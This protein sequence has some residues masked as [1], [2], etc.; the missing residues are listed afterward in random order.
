MRYGNR[1]AK[2]NVKVLV[3]LLLVVV[4]LGVSLVAARQI[5]RRILSQMALEAGTAAFDNGDWAT[6]ASR[7]QEYLGRNPDDIEI[8]K[9]YAEAR[10]SVRPLEPASV[11]R[12]ISAYRRVMQLD[13]NDDVA[14]E[15]L[16]RLYTAVQ[17]FPDLAYIARRR[18]EQAQDDKNARLWLAEA[19][20]RL[21]KSGEARNVL[22]MLR[23]DL[24]GLADKHTEYVRVCALMSQIVSAE[25]TAAARAEGLQ[26]LDRAVAYDPNSVE[27]LAQRAG[28]RRQVAER[29]GAGEADRDTFMALARADLEAADAIGTDTPKY[30]YFLGW[31]W[32]VHGDLERAE[33]ELRAAQ[34]LPE[35]AVKEHFLDVRDWTIAKF[36]LASQLM[37]QRGNASE[38][39]LLVDEVLPTLTARRHRVQVLPTAVRVYVTAGRVADARKCLDEYVEAQYA[40]VGS[41]SG[42]TGTAEARLRLAFLRALVAQAEDNAYGVIDVLQPALASDPAR[43]E[44]WRLLAEA[45]SRTDQPRRAVSALIQYLRL[46][47]RDPDMM[48]QLAKEYLKLRDW[49]NAF[50]T[51]R[52][53]ESPDPTDIVLRL[54]RIEASIYVATEQEQT[55]DT[56]RLSALSDELT[57]LR[58]EHPDR[59]DIRILQAMIAVYLDQP[60]KAEEELRLAIDECDEPLRAEMQLIRHLYRTKRLEE[61]VSLCQTACERHPEVA[62]PWL[63]LSGLY[64]AQADNDSA[65]ACLREGLKAVVGKWEQR[66]VSL[67]LALLELMDGDRG[68]G[69]GILTG[70]AAQDEREVYARTLLLGTREIQ[71]NRTKAQELIEE[72]KAAEGQSGLMWRLHQAA[73]HL[74]SDDWRSKQQDMAELLQQCIDSDP[75]WSS[76]VLLL[77]EM[78][79]KLNDES[80]VESV[81]RQGLVRNPSATDIADKLMGLL[82]KQG[83]YADAEQVLQQIEADAQVA[84]AWHVRMALGTRDFSRAI[85]E[86]RLRVDNDNRDAESRILLAR[87]L[88]WQTRDAQQ[89]FRYLDE[90]QEITSGSLTLAAARASILRAEGRTE[91]G[92]DVLDEYVTSR[93]DF[94]AYMMRAA[95]LA[96]EGNLEAAES[97]YRKLT[98][99]EQ[100]SSMGHMLLANFYAIHSRLDDAV[101]TLREGLRVQP[102][103]LG[104]RRALMMTLLQRGQAEDRQQA[105]DMLASLEA[106]MPEDPELMRLRAMQ[107]LREPTP[108]SLAAAT[109]KLEEV[110]KLEPTAVDAH[111][112]LIEIALQEGD[113]AKAREMA[114]RALGANP[115]NAALLAA[116][117]RVELALE[118][119]QM[120]TQLANL[121]LQADPNNAQARDVIVTAAQ[122]T[123]DRALLEQAVTLVDKWLAH[124]PTNEQLTLRRARLMVALQQPRKAIPELEAYCRTEAGSRDVTALVTLADVYRL[125]GN[126]EK[127]KEAID[128]AEA[129]DP[130]SQV[131]AHARLLWLIAQKRYNE[132]TGVVSTYLAVQPRDAGMLVKAGRALL[133]CDA[134][135]AKTEAVRLFERVLALDPT[136]LDGRLGLASSLYQAGQH[137]RAEQIRREVLAENIEDVNAC[138]TIASTLYLTGYAEGGERIY[139]NLLQRDPN[140]TRVLN[141]L[142]WIIQEHYQRYDE[143]LALA[144][145][146]LAVS[147]R[148]PAESVDHVHLLD[149]RGTIL[150]NMPGRLADA[151]RDFEEI[152][153]LSATNQ[154]RQAKALLQLGRVC[155]KQGDLAQAK[156]H[157]ERSL[158]VDRR[159]AVFTPAEKSEIATLLQ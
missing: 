95:Y 38:S 81:C 40:Q 159:L 130:N 58:Q 1:D 101:A 33:A 49:N 91:E 36:L 98:T 71:E 8:L 139:R 122:T 157:L 34:Q 3:I 110:V 68:A 69:I 70:L 6:A 131:V 102:E 75:E 148:R 141:D 63:S 32:L 90:A 76:P 2:V 151:K 42:Q 30:L 103:D 133:S 85:D 132:L 119:T 120:A 82:E 23:S 129:V 144:D 137:D 142:A 46:R 89:A 84:S 127:A 54:L 7:L 146:G 25:D 16:A 73:L 134:G 27:A 121:A 39:A 37:M 124:E 45:F 86:L 13:A 109:Q 118:N 12:A 41:P 9:K 135:E 56:A 79:E 74:S 17:N 51:A 96:N 50:E 150:M 115:E 29:L 57:T 93:S 145:R 44:L 125:D 60:E 31:E 55:I 52:L 66:A 26:W 5:R 53:A 22:E 19:L 4:A 72:L 64:V 147:S 105:L 107:L 113:Y 67:R 156:R 149:T 111:L 153:R 21:N 136:S 88:Y 61:A 123:G 108:A 154:R 116:R 99:F 77:A 94:G 80:R 152:V 97:D 65:R 155:A 158:E 140:S 20:M 28:Y 126:T 24:E 47:P 48:L 59:V 18:L 43:P 114:L 83:R 15:K 138:V 78:Y 100:Y 143:A 104:L 62:E 10:L 112:T 87:L 117:S 128:R 14:Y 11:S 106:K 35:E 92:R